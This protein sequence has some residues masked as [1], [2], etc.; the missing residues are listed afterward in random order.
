MRYS[1]ALLSSLL[2]ASGV[3]SAQTI[4]LGGSLDLTIEGD[5]DFEIEFADDDLGF[6]DGGDAPSP[7]EWF[8]NQ[9]HEIDFVARGVADAFPIEYGVDLQLELDTSDGTNADWDEAWIFLESDRLGELRLGNEDDVYDFTGFSLGA[10]TVARGTGGID[11]DQRTAPEF[12]L[13]SSGEATKFIYF[14]PR[15]FGFA[16]AFSYAIDADDRGTNSGANEATDVTT[17]AGNYEGSLFGVD[18]GAFAGATRATVEGDGE[19]GW[20]I[21]GL[22]GVFGVEIAGQYGDE[23][24]DF[25]GDESAVAPAFEDDL[26]GQPRENFWNVGIGSDIGNYGLSFNYQRDNFRGDLGR[27]NFIVGGDVGVLPGISLR[28]EAAYLDEDLQGGGDRNGFNG[29]LQLAASF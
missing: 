13:A 4:S 20:A 9:D 8:L 15:F 11:G 3:A 19:V 29:L 7:R 23:S 6:T 25:P 27:D 24:G 12:E 21:G 14:S 26:D 1:L 18:F 28:G 10:G 17:L 16:G 5:S 22:I 2:L